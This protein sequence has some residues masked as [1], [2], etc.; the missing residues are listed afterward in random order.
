M[1]SSP[2]ALDLPAVEA[3]RDAVDAKLRF[4]RSAYRGFFGLKNLA[5]V[6]LKGEFPTAPVRLHRHALV[7][8]SSLL[9]LDL[10]L[11]PLPEFALAGDA[12]PMQQLAVQ[13]EHLKASPN[14]SI[15]PRIGR[16]RPGP[17]AEVSLNR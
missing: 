16:L 6:G 14:P 17:V 8:K 10:D 9:S 15:H 12:G 3:R 1:K 5:R 4:V 11:E 7:V 2:G 13:L